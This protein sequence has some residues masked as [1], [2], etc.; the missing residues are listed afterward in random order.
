ML[1]LNYVVMEWATDQDPREPFTAISISGRTSS[2]AAR[3][4]WGSELKEQEGPDSGEVVA[5]AFVLELEAPG[6]S[7]PG[8]TLGHLCLRLEKGKAGGWVPSG[9]TFIKEELLW[10]S[11]A[12]VNMADPGVRAKILQKF[13]HQKGEELCMPAQHHMPRALLTCSQVLTIQHY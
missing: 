6:Y 13:K 9:P 7:A 3:L 11:L 8:R 1:C 2:Q 12:R 4:G 5:V 10:L